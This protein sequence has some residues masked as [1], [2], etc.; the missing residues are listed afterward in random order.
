ML[1]SYFDHDLVVDRVDE[2]GRNLSTVLLLQKSLNLAYGH[3]P[4]IH[5]DDLVV[6]AREASLM[7]GNQQRF[8]TAVAVARHLDTDLAVLAQ[9]RLGARSLRWLVTV[10]G[11]AALGG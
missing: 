4:G 5:G 3:V 6:E 11:L 8:E 2:I 10:I 1:G 7:L 9:D